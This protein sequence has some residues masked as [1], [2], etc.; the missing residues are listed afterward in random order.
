VEDRPEAARVDALFQLAHL[1]MVATV[2][3]QSDRYSGLLR[4]VDHI[5]GIFFLKRERLLRE[6]VLLCF[7]SV[8]HV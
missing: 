2:V 5:D 7:R 4:S 1:R 8:D 6:D 3:I